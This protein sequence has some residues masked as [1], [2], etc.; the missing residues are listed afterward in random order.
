MTKKAKTWTC[1]GAALACVAAVL[2]F[3]LRNDAPYGVEYL[4]AKV[5][6]TTI[7]NSVT[8]TGTIEPVTE[9]EVGTQ[10]SG[11]ISHI[12]VDYNSV[13]KKGQV[14]AELDKTNLVSQLNSAKS[15][16]ASAQANLK[17]QQ[18]NY[19]RIRTLH[20]KGLVSDDDFETARLAWQ[21]AE[22]SVKER[23]EAVSTAQ[24]NLGY[25]TITSPI[26]GTVLTKDVEEGQTVA[27]SYSTP[28]LF[29]IAKDLRDMRVIADV[30]EADIG[31]VDEGQRVTFTVDAFPDDTFD[32]TV[33][34][35]RQE[36]TTEDNVV[37]YE[38]VISS[39]N[40]DLKLKPGL[41]ANV[42]I[43]TMERTGVA[44]LPTKALRF[45]PTSETIGPKD[46]IVDCKGTNKVWVKDGRTFKAYAVQ[47]GITNGTRTEIISGLPADAQVI[48][49]MKDAGSAS[50]S[51]D[52]AT[53]RSPFA[54]GPPNQNKNKKK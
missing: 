52:A 28:T 35:V 5:E 40:D 17:Y 1:A 39:P 3:A 29:T 51:E 49:E 53:E 6:K 20:D 10:V 43:H 27:S 47:T 11:M 33:T 48:V 9:V 2:Y 25:A 24:T 42:T 7:G 4:T 34:Q 36:G 26:D 44:S 19:G 50:E 21:Q 13:V 18:T 38:V 41:T 23:Q 22:E 8:A 37:T 16:L 46:K 45:T 31:Q 12:Y 15:Q 32:G 54:P 14:I 30:D